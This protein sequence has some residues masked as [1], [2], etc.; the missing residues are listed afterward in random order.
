MEEQGKKL[1]LWNIVGVGLGSAIGT[2][3]FVMLG[4]GIA[5][6]GR[7]IMTVVMAGCLF[8]TL[9]FWYQFAMPSMFVLR[10]GDY[11]MKSMLFNPMMTGVAAWFVVLQG[12]GMSTS[13]TVIT[14]YLVILIPALG[15]VRTLTAVVLMALFFMTTLKG[16]R[17]VTLVGNWVTVILVAALALFVGFGFFRVNPAEFFSNSN[18]DGPFFLNGAGGFISALAIMSFACM[19]TT[20][21]PIAMAAVTDKPKRTIPLAII[22]IAICLAAIYGLMAYVAAGVLPYEQIAGANISVTAEA[23]FPK[24]IYLFFVAG[25]GIGAVGSTLLATLAALRYPLMQ[26]AEDGWLPAVFKKTTKGGYPYMVYGLFFVISE[27]PLLMGMSLDALVSLTMIPL[28]LMNT[29]INLACVILPKKYPDQWEKRSIKWPVW[30][31][32]VCCVLGA[33]CAIMVAYNLFVQ[34]GTRDSILA[35]GLCVM[36]VVLSVIRLKQGAVNTEKLEQIK[37][38]TIAQAIADDVN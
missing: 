10:G 24:S 31:W 26:V 37:Q 33:G 28:M 9:A 1:G 15:K 13:A 17:F 32:K 35:A 4:Y 18:P 27:A 3:I 2:G 36:L 12:I 8:M 16:S 25:G 6:T 34:L 30:L 22:T 23:I 11:S 19:G 29:Y 20:Y 5:Y 7:S 21:N 38:A 14:D